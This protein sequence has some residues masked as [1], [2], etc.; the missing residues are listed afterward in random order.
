MMKTPAVLISIGLT[1]LNNSK[2]LMQWLN[3][4]WNVKLPENV[5]ISIS[6]VLVLYKLHACIAQLKVQM[7]FSYFN[8]IIP[9]Y[10]FSNINCWFT[11]THAMF[12]S[13]QPK[14]RPPHWR[15][16]TRS[17]IHLKIKSLSILM[18]FLA[19]NAQMKYY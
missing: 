4:S 8:Y 6:G 16:I 11:L 17:T 1:V 18:S 13:K 15:C 9:L 7:S 12:T 2:I 19:I 14:I 10:S 5:I 3:V